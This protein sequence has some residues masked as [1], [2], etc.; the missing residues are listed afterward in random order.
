[1]KPASPTPDLGAWWVSGG[2][3]GQDGY[4][5]GSPN[6]RYIGDGALGNKSGKYQGHMGGVSFVFCEGHAAWMKLAKTLS[7]PQ[8][9]NPWTQGSYATNPGQC[10][11]NKIPL[12][13]PKYR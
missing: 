1:M 2:D 13:L 10:Y 4:V 8:M 12:T 7:D 3:G 6:G 11:L 5:W 9:W